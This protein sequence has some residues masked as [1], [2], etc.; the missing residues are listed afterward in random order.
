MVKSESGDSG[1]VRH[2]DI[3]SIITMF[4]YIVI[5]INIERSGLA[6]SMKHIISQEKYMNHY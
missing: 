1:K 3:V 5:Y 4:I 2:R 6:T